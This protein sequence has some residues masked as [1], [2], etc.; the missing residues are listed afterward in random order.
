MQQ[1]GWF[2]L[3][4]LGYQIVVN[5]VREFYSNMHEVSDNSF[6]TFVREQELNSTPDLL[7]QVLEIDRVEDA[8]FPIV[9]NRQINYNLVAKE[10]TGKPVAWIGGDIAHHKLTD[11][12]HLLNILIRHNVSPKVNK[13]VTK[14]DGY[15]FY[16][17]GTQRKV[18]ISLAVF[19]RMAKIHTASHNVTL[20]FPGVISKLLVDMGK[21]AKPNEDIIIPKSKID[22]FT[23]EKSKSHITSIK[24]DDDGEGDTAGPSGASPS[25]VGPSVVADS[26]AGMSGDD[27]MGEVAI[28][29]L[30]ER[31]GRL[32]VRVN[33]GFAEMQRSF[34]EMLDRLRRD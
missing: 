26:D 14:E 19:H 31:I 7:S 27:Q 16:C 1:R 32:E 22:R 9:N 11:S 23:L 33:E 13:R 2:T 6:K 8:H 10:L 30:N 25:G 5:W 21:L 20:P 12:Y 15:L 3:Y 24:L 4:D 28:H 34:V 18:D 29:A 17:I